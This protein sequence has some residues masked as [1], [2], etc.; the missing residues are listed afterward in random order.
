MRK[1]R[2]RVLEKRAEKEGRDYF[3]TLEVSVVDEM[4]YEDSWLDF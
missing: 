3:Q 4:A 1:D 2:D